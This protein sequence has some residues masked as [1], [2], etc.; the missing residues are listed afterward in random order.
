MMD[1]PTN[2]GIRQ[3]LEVMVELGLAYEAGHKPWNQETGSFEPHYRL[4][5]KGE[6]ATKADF[7][8]VDR[9][10]MRRWRTAQEP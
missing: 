9:E 8:A 3:T 5:P 2:E 6:A 1:K 7:D 4:T 10:A